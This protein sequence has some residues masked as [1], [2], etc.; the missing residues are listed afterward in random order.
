MRTAFFNRQAG[1]TTLVT[2]IVVMVVSLAIGVA[3]SQRAVSHIRQTTHTGQSEQAYHCA[4]AGAELALQEITDDSFTLFGDIDGGVS[5]SGTL[6]DDVP[7]GSGDTVCSYQYTIAELV[8]DS[9]LTDSVK[10]DDVL[11]VWLEDY[12]GRVTVYFGNEGV[13]HDVSLEVTE[14]TGSDPT[15]YTMEKFAYYCNTP[16]GNDFTRAWE[17]SSPHLSEG[18]PCVVPGLDYSDNGQL[19][20]LRPL[21]ADV[22]FLIEFSDTPPSQ[23]YLIRSTGTAGLAKRTLEV[24]RSKPQLPAIF[25]YTIY[26]GREL[27]K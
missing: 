17:G 25:D 26:S 3:A 4:E 23:G 10:Q 18:Y 15:D 6:T 2:I 22:N 9:A 1:Q 14:V 11:Q 12:T 7:G 21:Y 5:G 27:T 24:T 13:N 16:Q 20:R 8:Q 19:L